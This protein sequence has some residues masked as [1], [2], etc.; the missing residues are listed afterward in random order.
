MCLHDGHMVFRL[1][2]ELWIISHASCQF[3]FISFAKL[4][5]NII[6][7]TLIPVTE[8]QDGIHRVMGVSVNLQ[9]VDLEVVPQ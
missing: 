2:K 1:Y 4:K 3:L 9:S 8:L 6:E 5:G 7:Y